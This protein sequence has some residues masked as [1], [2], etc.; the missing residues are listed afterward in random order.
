M[1]QMMYIDLMTYHPD[2]ILVKV[3][4]ASMAVGL[5]A[6]VPLIDHRVVEYALTLPGTCLVAEGQGKRILR[7]ILY[8]HVPQELIDRPKQGFGVPLARWLRTDLRDWAEAL[9]SAKRLESEGYFVPAPI[10]ARWEEHLS[11]RRD[12]KHSLWNILMFEAWLERQQD[13]NA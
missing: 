1:R 6:R 9:L 8:R 10:R 5:E 13:K 11:A 7:D 4:R 12:W 3:D 2:D